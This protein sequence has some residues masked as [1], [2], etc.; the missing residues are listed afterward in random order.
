LWPG[1]RLDVV[2]RAPKLSGRLLREAAVRALTP[3]LA[4]VCTEVAVPKTAAQALIDRVDAGAVAAVGLHPIF[5][6][7]SP[8]ANAQGTFVAERQYLGLDLCVL[9]TD[10]VRL[11][12]GMQDDVDA[13]AL[14]IARRMNAIGGKIETCTT[15]YCGKP[16]SRPA[17]AG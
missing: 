1:M 14:Q 15:P 8:S 16:W 7:E 9:R 6:S 4:V 13:L 5:R 2:A 12:D 11:C 17:L 3:W 10:L